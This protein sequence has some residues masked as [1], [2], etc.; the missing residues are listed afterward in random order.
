MEQTISQNKMGMQSVS[1]LMLGMGIPMIISMMVQAF[2]NIVDS[3]FVSNIADA[4]GV[5]NMGDYAVNALTLS[6]PVQMLIIAIGVGTG[7]GVNAL[8]SR[9]LGA[10]QQEQANRVAG[11]A[12]FVGICTYVVFLLFGLFGVR[13]FLETQ[14]SDPIILELGYEYL[15]ICSIVSFGAVGSMIYEKLLQSTG[16]TV[17][18]TIAQLAGAI[19]NV[20]LDPILIYGWLG[21]P[22]MGITGAAVATVI[23][24]ILTLVLSMV[25]HYGWNREINGSPR[26][27]KPDG[28][29]IGRIYKV[30]APAILMQALMSVM[31]YGVN[32]IFGLVSASAVTA[33][34]IYYKIQQ[35][36]FFAA[37]GL[38][39][40]IIPIVAFNYGKNDRKRVW[41][42]VRYG[43]LYTLLLMLIGA[44]GLQLF[45]KPI[46]GV[47][48][49][50]EES[51]MLCIRAI[52][53]V[54]FGYLFAGANIAFQGIFQALG[55][56]VKSLVLSLIRLIVVALPLAWCLTLVD[57]AANM[58][59]LAFPI[60]EGC[61]FVVA[62]VL[63]RIVAKAKIEKL[64]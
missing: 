33:Y 31:A 9:S 4:D 43:L 10:G 24:Q 59:W 39:N 62:L 3:Y 15:S 47:F 61:G 21:A 51:Q 57:D 44:V 45:A 34:G 41:D 48:A 29:T 53:V 1:K 17:F 25:F 32:I 30:G 64:K 18:S 54:T 12:I 63:M 38:N 46:C 13:W 40:A 22:E 7:V 28:K 36:V 50:S 37:F 14:T 5:A 42:G 11:N 55:C 35:F 2:Y 56:G 27:L 20:V 58:V 49:L 52:R 6:F 60:A 19:A 23:G 16:K 8:L 26:Y